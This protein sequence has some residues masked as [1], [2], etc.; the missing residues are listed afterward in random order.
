MINKIIEEYVDWKAGDE[1]SMLNGETKEMEH[2]VVTE[3]SFSNP[4]Y[5]KMYGIVK[6]K[7]GDEEDWVGQF[8]SFIQNGGTIKRK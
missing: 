7:N 8:G 5:D 1:V 2:G 6:W 4:V 3:E